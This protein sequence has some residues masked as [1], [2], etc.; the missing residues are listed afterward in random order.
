MFPVEVFYT[1]APEKDYF[2]AVI[3]TVMQ[4]HREEKPGD[5]LVFL[6][7]EEEIENACAE[8]RHQCKDL[9]DSVGEAMVLPCYSTLTP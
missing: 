4:I 8:I 9:K 5:I 3:K 1:E 6:T 7:G 2:E